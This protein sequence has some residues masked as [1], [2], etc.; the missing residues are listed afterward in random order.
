MKSRLL[1]PTLI[2]LT[3]LGFSR[4]AVATETESSMTETQQQVLDTVLS[5]TRAFESRDIEAVLAHYNHDAVIS[6][7]PGKPTSGAS[8]IREQ[9]TQ[10]FAINPAFDYGGHKVVVTGDTALHIAPWDM[11]GTAPDGS[12]ISDSGLSVS[13][14]KRQADKSWRIVLDEPYGALVTQ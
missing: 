12:A 6:F 3:L 2:T 10:F 11:K 1:I 14:L 13:V 8:N 9:F 7:E 4:P 5:M